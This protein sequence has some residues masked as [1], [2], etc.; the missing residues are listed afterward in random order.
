MVVLALAKPS[1]ES[2]AQTQANDLHEGSHVN[3]GIQSTIH[4][5]DRPSTG[6]TGIILLGDADLTLLPIPGVG[7][8]NG[9]HLEIEAFQSVVQRLGLPRINRLSLDTIRWPHLRLLG[10]RHD[11][12]ESLVFSVDIGSLRLPFLLS[13]STNSRS[14]TI[15][16]VGGDLG[17]RF[18]SRDLDANL[19]SETPRAHV[20]SF[21]VE[22]RLDH[23]FALSE[24]LDLRFFEQI[25]ALLLAGES[26]TDSG[27][28][29]PYTSQRLSLS[30]GAS[31]SLDITPTPAYRRV[32]RTHPG[33]GEVTRLR[34][35]NAG[36]RLRLNLLDVRGS[37]SPINSVNDQ[38]GT[39]QA[40]V[41]I[42]GE[43]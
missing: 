34:V 42:G 36:N 3:A 5:A 35:Q 18:I 29:R 21:Q 19:P 39:I 25:T 33:T 22:C 9:T 4:H 11:R 14:Y 27:S 26:Y 16:R 6:D 31:L 20:A 13:G 37:A 40:T 12:N 43:L 2:F 41:G 17:Y 15:V 24:R 10:F 23:Q 28:R 38:A 32:P 1:S 30:G 7:R 8:T